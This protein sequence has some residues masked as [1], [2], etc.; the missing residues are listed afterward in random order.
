MIRQQIKNSYFAL[1]RWLVKPNTLLA[2]LRYRRASDAE[3]FYLHLGSG[4]VYIPGMINIEGNIMR[5]KDLWLDL[6]NPLPFP[7]RSVYF[8]Y[9]SHTLE[10]F[11]PDEAMQ[12]L[13]EIHRVLRDDGVAR[14]ATPSF[15][16]ALEIAA[17]HPAEDPQ[18]AFSDPHGQAI[19]YLFCDGQHK[20]AYSFT[21]MERFAR[22]AGFTGITNHSADPAP[23]RYGKIEV[24]DELAGSLIVELRR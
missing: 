11:Y 15:E 7:D 21:V 19:D 23:K 9:C 4:P 18:R 13:R 10:H 20:Y 22:D 12:L 5:R 8:V 2:R 17:G 3:G 24:G 1:N 16:H 14:I 6:Q